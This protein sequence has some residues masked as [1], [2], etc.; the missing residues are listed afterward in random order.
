[1]IYAV[2]FCGNRFEIRD[3]SEPA[4]TFGPRVRQ[5][6]KG[7]GYSQRDFAEL[8]TGRLRKTGYKSLHFTYLSKIEHEDSK[9][10]IPS[11][12]VILAI[13]EV[14]DADTDELLALVGK[15]RHD[16]D[17]KLTHKPA[18]RAFFN[19]AIDRLSGK[20]WQDLLRKIQTLKT[21]NELSSTQHLCLN[22]IGTAFT[23]PTAV[24]DFL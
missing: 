4:K 3:A 20:D 14:L 12:P 11:V 2:S 9:T 10:G 8:A 16:L 5:L 13:A 24:E 15:A 1:M 23:S 21:Q 18:A 6:R 22:V 19:Y 17:R 7:K